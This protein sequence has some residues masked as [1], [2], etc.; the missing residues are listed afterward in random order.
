MRG[1]VIL[2]A[3]CGGLLAHGAAATPWAPLALIGVDEVRIARLRL[4]GP[5]ASLELDGL[6][7]RRDPAEP[8]VLA[9]SAGRAVSPALPIAPLALSLRLRDDAARLAWDG[10]ARLADG[11]RLGRLVGHHDRA[12]GSGRLD[13]TVTPLRMG[14]NGVPLGAL[15][16][17]LATT[18]T[19]VAGEIG[20]I[21]RLD[22]GRRAGERVELLLRDL[23]FATGG[24]RIERL[25]GVVVLDGLFP[26]RSAGAQQLA[27]ALVD[28]GVPLTAGLASLE[29]RRDGALVLHEAVFELESG[30]IRADPATLRPPYRDVELTLRADGL[31]LGQLVG[32]LAI[33][34]LEAEGTLDGTLPVHLL[35]GVELEIRDG[36]LA[37][38]GRGVIRWRPAEPPAALVGAGA[39][40][41]ILLQALR[42]FRYEALS[43]TLEGRTDGEMRG[44]L[45]IRG[46]NP[47]LYD[48]YPVELN[49]NLE[50]RLAAIVRGG[51]SAWRIPANIA[52]RI[53]AF[54]RQLR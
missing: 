34:G 24:G 14:A 36:Q 17:G 11:P 23:S 6:R 44:R 46:R 41:D 53:D 26:P 1:T 37:A 27:V 51:V 16:P 48:G 30:H 32:R 22:W 54:R 35:D 52:E 19:D 28:V 43:M 13:L 5:G 50:G 9:L 3:L 33:S 25:S 20:L 31:D 47:D 8:A 29:L 21:A 10:E 12:T 4:A 2:A 38:R 18:I 45:S 40:G 49:V 42:D 7:L 15:A 39:S